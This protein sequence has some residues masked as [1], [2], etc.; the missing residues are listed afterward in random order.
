[1]SVLITP[2]MPLDQMQGSFLFVITKQNVIK[3]LISSLVCH[4]TEFH[5]PSLA[6]SMGIFFRISLIP[7][8]FQVEYPRLSLTMITGGYF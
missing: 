4:K 6:N 2:A 7:T 5:R 8:L 3:S 1:M